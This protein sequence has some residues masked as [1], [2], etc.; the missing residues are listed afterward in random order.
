MYYRCINVIIKGD[1][2]SVISIILLF[3]NL[4]DFS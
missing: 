1:Y 2:Y 3:R 4:E